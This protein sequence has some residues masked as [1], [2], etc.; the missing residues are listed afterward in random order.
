M[1]NWKSAS[2]GG[3]SSIG[4]VS[5]YRNNVSLSNPATWSSLKFT[6]LSISYN[7]FESFLMNRSKNGYSNL[8]S[9]HLIVPMKKKHA[10]GIELHPYSYQKIE[11]IDSV[12][13]IIVF[14]D[15]LGIKKQYVQSGGIMALNIS[16]STSILSKTNLGISLQLLFGSSRQSKNLLLDDIPY[17][18]SSRLNYSG[19]NLSLFLKKNAF[20]LDFYLGSKFALKPLGAIQ[21]KFYPYFDTNKNGYHDYTFDYLNPGYDFPHPNDTPEPEDQRHINIHDPYTISIGLSKIVYNNL[22]LSFEAQ[23][24]NEYSNYSTE[25]PNGFNNRLIKSN[26]ISLGM[27]RFP[28]DQ[29]FSFIDN[30]TFRSGIFFNVHSFDELDYKKSKRVKL[31]NNVTELGYSLGFGYKF[32]AVGNQIDF[33]YSSSRKNYEAMGFREE[34]LKV[35]QISISIADIWFIKRRQR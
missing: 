19:V 18:V 12:N 20:G 29:S 14:D 30:M 4:L 3:A 27:I 7:G 11:I 23:G 25:I 34:N 24:Y 9:A 17:S 6:F 10:L 5:S 32:K 33:T 13:S 21:T 1:Q 15:T 8:Q 26:K 28:N 31:K 35:F 2:E 16:G 22:Q